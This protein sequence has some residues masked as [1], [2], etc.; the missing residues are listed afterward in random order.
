[1]KRI[2]LIKS[3]ASSSNNPAVV[4]EIKDFS[5]NMAEVGKKYAP[6]IADIFINRLRFHDPIKQLM[7]PVFFGI[8]Y[9]VQKVGVGIKAVYTN[10]TIGL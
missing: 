5:K 10:I 4:L 1:M 9:N 3:L 6:Y 2:T 8:F 7:D